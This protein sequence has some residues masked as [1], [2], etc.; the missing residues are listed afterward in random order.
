MEKKFHEYLL[1]S[2]RNLQIAD[3]MTYVTF[4]L[5]NENRLLLKILDEIYKGILNA[6]T[7]AITYE[8]LKIKIKISEDSTQNIENFL[9]EFSTEYSL[10]SD[11]L[12]KIIEIIEFHKKHKL[13]PMEFVKKEK[14]VIMSKDSRIDTLN[15]EK[16]KEY[17]SVSKSLYKKIEKKLF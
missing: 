7:A 9:K 1:D 13:S 12:R 14:V 16:T 10:N 17:L 3:H 6:T 8:C 2:K 15:I 5:I 4:P 11:E